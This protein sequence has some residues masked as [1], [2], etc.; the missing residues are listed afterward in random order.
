MT[1]RVEGA[2]V[3]VVTGSAP[4][5]GRVAG[6]ASCCRARGGAV[7]RVTGRRP[8]LPVNCKVLCT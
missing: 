8:V 5:G 1:L 7:D 4:G 6:S 2:V 3:A